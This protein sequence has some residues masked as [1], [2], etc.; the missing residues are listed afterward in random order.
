M[1]KSNVS[2]T[3]LDLVFV[4][5]SSPLMTTFQLSC[6]SNTGRGRKDVANVQYQL[7]A[8]YSNSNYNKSDFNYVTD[9]TVYLGPRRGNKRTRVENEKKE[10]CTCLM[11]SWRKE[12]KGKFTKEKIFARIV[13]W[14]LSFLYISL[15]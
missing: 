2:V 12:K 6:E 3:L 9:Q 11:D 5:I 1:I 7:L 4:F 14:K 13:S 10:L 8:I 15:L